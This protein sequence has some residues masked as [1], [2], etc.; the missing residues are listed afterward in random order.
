MKKKKKIRSN[1]HIIKCYYFTLLIRTK[2][3]PPLPQSCYYSRPDN[4]FNIN[5]KGRRTVVHLGSGHFSLCTRCKRQDELSYL[6][7][8]LE[9]N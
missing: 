3:I 6:C 5:E 2:N 7:T 8:C 4:L 1:N 9:I